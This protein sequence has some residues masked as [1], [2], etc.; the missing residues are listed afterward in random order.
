MQDTTF[1]APCQPVTLTFFDGDKT[2]CFPKVSRAFEWEQ[3]QAF[4]R[5]AAAGAPGAPKASR[6]YAIFAKLR[7]STEVDVA[8][9]EAIRRQRQPTWTMSPAQL[10]AATEHGYRNASHLVEAGAIGI[11]YDDFPTE[12]P[13]WRPG[14]WPCEVFAHSSHNYDPMHAPG[15]WRAVLRLD[16]PIPSSEYNRVKRALA[17]VLPRGC[18]VRAAHQPAFLPTC[19]AGAEVKFAHVPGKPLDWRKLVENTPKD[20]ARKASEVREPMGELPVDLIDALAE[21]WPI[22]REGRCYPAALALGGVMADSYWPLD[23][24]L[25]FAS[26]LFAK[27]DV[28]DRY[29]EVQVSVETRRT[30]PTVPVKGWP[31]LKECLR[32]SLEEVDALIDKMKDTIP[33]L[34]PPKVD[35]SKLMTKAEQKAEQVKANKQVRTQEAE[36]QGRRVLVTGSQAEVAQEIAADQLLGGVACEGKLW[37]QDAQGIW[38]EVPENV[39]SGWVDLWD[40]AVYV[41][42]EGKARQFTSGAS[43]TTGVAKKLSMQLFREDFFAEAPRGIPFRNG[44]LDVKT[45]QLRPIAECRVRSVLPFDYVPKEQMAAPK[46]WASYLGSI[47]GNDREAVDLIHEIIGYLLSG[48]TDLQKAFLFIG[49]PRGGKGTMFRLLKRLF[50]TAQAGFSLSA[51]DGRFAMAGLLGKSVVVDTD[52]RRSTS[53]FKDEGMV[54]ERFLRITGED[55][56]TVERKNREDVHTTMGCRILLGSNP[57]FGLRDVG[58]ALSS[59]LVI[60]KFPKS[61]LGKED[62]TLQARLESELPAIVALALDALD[63]LERRGHFVEPASSAEERESVE[64]SQEPML[65]FW[66]DEIDDSDPEALTPCAEVF[67]CANR[68]REREGH[69]RMS[70]Q[71]FGEF[72]RRRGVGQ[73]RPKV[74]GQRLPRHYKGVRLVNAGKTPLSVIGTPK[75]KAG[76]GR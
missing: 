37:K 5:H 67:E 64:R 21:R 12:P 41:D 14:S 69:R 59:R 60:L 42:P 66:E 16:S 55:E 46:A 71:A 61:F 25:E 13:D 2:N 34:R 8:E 52:V 7:P 17:K 33:G 43:S 35:L 76:P 27:A 39:L 29:R 20:T 36:Q 4:Y 62:T 1:P 73:V 57:P 51:L 47:W 19:P 53:T 24:I 56:L 18:I 15:K 38:E 31:Q 72:L 32:G 40:G 48:R 22:S 68:W 65:G 45:R 54:V 9:V 44:F 74:D 3:L 30:D 75:A 11:D 28:D 49:P 26:A 10:E 6:G 50:G 63:R 23:D 70:N 58:A